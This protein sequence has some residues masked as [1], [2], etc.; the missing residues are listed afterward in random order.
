MG[1]TVR[2]SVASAL[3]DTRS[4]G[5]LKDLQLDANGLHLGYTMGGLAMRQLSHDEANKLAEQ[6][7]Q[8][9]RGF[10]P[11][12]EQL[13]RKYTLAELE[14]DLI[15]CMERAAWHAL[16]L[17]GLLNAAQAEDRRINNRAADKAR[18]IHREWCKA[19]GM[20]C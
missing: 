8:A 15:R 2:P 19:N 14:P 13:K 10:R 11:T 17:A 18:A 9:A 12:D 1:I 5:Y 16:K 7:A 4:Y 3:R 6:A 20:S